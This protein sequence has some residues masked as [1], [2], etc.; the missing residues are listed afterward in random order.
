MNAADV[1]KLMSQLR[2]AINPRH[3]NMRNIQGPEGRLLKLRKTVTA[4][5]KYERVELFQQ[6]AHET[7]GYAERVSLFKYFQQISL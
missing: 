7:Q 3:R 1:S 5:I 4:L 2:V 6:R